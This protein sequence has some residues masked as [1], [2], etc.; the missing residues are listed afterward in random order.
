MTELYLH[1]LGHFHPEIEITN[2]FL[3][4]LD[5][6]TDDAWIMQ[7]VGIRSRRTSLPLDYIRETRNRDVRAAAEAAVMGT[8]E[9]GARAAEMAIRRSGVDRTQIGM[10]LSG[11]C[12]VDVVTPAEACDVAR[13]LELQVPG[14]DV[15]SACTS[16]LAQ[17]HLL[18]MMRPEALPPFVLVV[19]QESMSRLVDYD[20]RST[21][22]L[23]G[24]GAAAAV[25]SA[26]V[27]G[28]AR[29]LGSS[30]ESN[31]A[32]ASK[33]WVPRTGHFVQEGR[34]VQMFAIKKSISGYRRL[35]EDWEDPDR[36]LHLVAHQANLRMLE[37]MSSRCG[38]EPERHHTNCEFFG[39]TGASSSAVVISQNWDKWTARD[40]IA[41]VGVGA[42]LT[43]AH[44]LLRFG[45][46]EA[47]AARGVAA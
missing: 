45:P 16:F 6:G 22:V 38:V 46:D 40:D 10:L 18:S 27:P 33:V 12:A 1:G 32:G 39:N 13:K 41:V 43:W 20:D 11:S 9:M 28:P 3:E 14:F 15:N 35:K 31:P 19:A 34:S 36:A 8:A 26:T 24:D 47:G 29:V 44:Y 37:T 5:I 17:L 42:G 21:A 2:R 4:E 23:F 7:R 30:V 25:V